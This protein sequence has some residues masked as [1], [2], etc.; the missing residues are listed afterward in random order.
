MERTGSLKVERGVRQGCLRS[1]M[2]FNVYSELIMMH[3]LFS[4]LLACLFVGLQKSNNSHIING[5]V[6]LLHLETIYITGAIESMLECDNR[7]ALQV[8]FVVEGIF[9]TFVT[10]L[11]TITVSEISLICLWYK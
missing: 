10:L 5:P 7:A 4:T 9:D 6:P 1:Q 2:L 8:I 11:T 3:T